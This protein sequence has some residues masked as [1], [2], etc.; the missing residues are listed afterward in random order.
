MSL[1]NQVNPQKTETLAV[2]LSKLPEV[3]QADSQELSDE[4][5][6]T[7]AGGI[8]VQRRSNLAVPPDPY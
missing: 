2:E 1:E 7:V 4:E 3:E 6:E 8:I 5:L